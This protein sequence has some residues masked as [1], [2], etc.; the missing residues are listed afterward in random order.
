MYNRV[1]RKVS[2]AK[3]NCLVYQKI[4]KSPA[5]NTKLLHSYSK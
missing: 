3:K 4:P 2:E 5:E 1:S